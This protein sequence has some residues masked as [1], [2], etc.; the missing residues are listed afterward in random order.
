MV[1]GG[2]YSRFMALVPVPSHSRSP[3]GKITSLDQVDWPPEQGIRSDH[4]G[5]SP[6]PSPEPMVRRMG[7]PFKRVIP[8]L[9]KNDL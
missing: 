5:D 8:I 3:D 1:Y 9:E 2:V 6:L 7:M 4:L